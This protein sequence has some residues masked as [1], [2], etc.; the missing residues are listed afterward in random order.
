MLAKTNQTIEQATSHFVDISKAYKSLTDAET[1]HNLEKYGHPDG[2]IFDTWTVAIPKWMVE[3]RGQ[4]IVLLIYG[5]IFG[6]ALPFL[7]VH[8]TVILFNSVSLSLY[9][10]GSLVVLFA[11]KDSAWVLEF[12]YPFLG[13]ES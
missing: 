7:L 2:K 5:L 3:G 11:A 13:M 1:R 9:G 10:S 12:D 6:L 4:V 8:F